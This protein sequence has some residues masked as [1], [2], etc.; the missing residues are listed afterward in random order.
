MTYKE[1]CHNI[2]HLFFAINLCGG[3]RTAKGGASAFFSLIYWF[4]N[5]AWNIVN[6]D[7]VDKTIYKAISAF[8]VEVCADIYSWICRFV[9]DIVFM[10]T[11]YGKLLQGDDRCEVIHIHRVAHLRVLV[12]LVYQTNSSEAWI[13]QDV[14]SNHHHV[15][16]F[17]EWIFF[18]YYGPWID[19]WLYNHS[20]IK[21]HWRQKANRNNTQGLHRGATAD[22]PLLSSHSLSRINSCEAGKE[23][24]SDI[25]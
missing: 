17:S 18:H 13:Y 7:N 8:Y 15:S 16:T 3:E 23:G 20:R 12:F 1:V 25:R 10:G 21:R 5:G 2:P 11:I 19:N 9:R 14:S 24:R 22:Y 6:T 4:T